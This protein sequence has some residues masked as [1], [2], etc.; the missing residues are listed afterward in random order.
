MQ[1]AEIIKDPSHRIGKLP[2]ANV[3]PTRV[4][5]NT[6]LSE[7]ATIMLSQDF[8]Q[9]PVMTSDRDVKG[10]ITWKSMASRLALGARSEEVRQCMETAHII[11]SDAPVFD[12][13]DSIVRH[14]YVLVRDASGRI[15]GIVTSSDLAA[16]FKLFAEPFLLLGAIEHGIR[17]IIES[18]NF[19]T[20]EIAAWKVP[21]DGGRK[22]TRVADFTL[23]ECR[24]FLEDPR[25]WEKTG[26]TVDRKTFIRL[27]ERVIRI[28]NDVMHFDPDGVSPEGLSE[29]Q[30]FATFLQ[31]ILV[32]LS[33]E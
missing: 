9:L 6:S 24:R 11:D 28:R 30:H 2:S 27:L 32:V 17:W 25:N 7:A 33:K 12:T 14:Q 15:V 29:L 5:P 10:V 18:G 23:G 4:A 22:I 3:S 1:S 31:T 16:Q 19:T 26:M 20:E 13:I 21:T 8:S